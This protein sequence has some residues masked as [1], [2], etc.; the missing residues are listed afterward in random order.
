MYPNICFYSGLDPTSC[1]YK[2]HWLEE[3][4]M[5]LHRIKCAVQQ[6]FRK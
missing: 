5:V 6:E 4:N 1:V 2:Q 3:K